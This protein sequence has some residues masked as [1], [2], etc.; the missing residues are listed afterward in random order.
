MFSLRLTIMIVWL[1]F[2]NKNL[3]LGIVAQV[4]EESKIIA[5]SGLIYFI[6]CFE[7]LIVVHHESTI[8]ILA[9]KILA[10]YQSRQ[11]TINYFEWID[12]IQNRSTRFAKVTY[13]LTCIRS[14]V[15]MQRDWMYNR[16]ICVLNARHSRAAKR[17]VSID[18]L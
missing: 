7:Y 17:E 12:G 2:I 13:C 6:I 3:F 16:F 1:L 11:Y 5:L 10:L 8:G 9:S 15:F 18:P 4:L 14:V